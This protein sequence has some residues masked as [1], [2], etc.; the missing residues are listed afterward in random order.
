MIH[1]AFG[2]LSLDS[3]RWAIDR[4][5]GT[6]RFS[7]RFSPFVL[8]GRLQPWLSLVSDPKIA[9]LRKKIAPSERISLVVTPTSK[10][11]TA[12]LEI[13]EGLLRLIGTQA[14]SGSSRLKLG[15]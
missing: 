10:S 14:S 15:R 1:I 11:L 13:Q 7:N 3:V 6:R 12:R 9:A 8:Q 5:S 4:T 2:G